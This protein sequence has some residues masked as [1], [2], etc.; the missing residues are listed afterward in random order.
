MPKRTVAQLEALL[1]ERD[2]ENARLAADL[3]ESV[4]ERASVLVENARLT[5]ELAERS[6][7]QTALLR[8]F[9]DQAVI[10]IENARLFRE[11]NESNAGLTE[12]LEQQTATSRVLEVISRSPTDLQTVLDTISESARRLCASDWSVLSM[13]Q[14]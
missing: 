4:D 10:A 14:D 3:A 13:V 9:A 2:R 6:E 12:A 7:Q 8:T 5:A 11:L 1:A